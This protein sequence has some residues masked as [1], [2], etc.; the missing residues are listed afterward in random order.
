MVT[1]VIIAAVDDAI[2]TRKRCCPRWSDDD[3]ADSV[4]CS[5]SDEFSELF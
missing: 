5:D 1:F 4:D 2:C 3:T